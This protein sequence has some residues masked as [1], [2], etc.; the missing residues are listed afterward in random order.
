MKKFAVLLLLSMFLVASA[1]N[2][3]AEN[4]FSANIGLGWADEYEL[5]DGVDSV[6]LAFQQG[7]G[8]NLALGHSF[9]N[10]LRA[11]VELGYYNCDLDEATWAG[12]GSGH[13]RGDTTLLIAM[14]N[15]YYDFFPESGVSP[16]IGGGI[17]YADAE[18]S[19]SGASADDNVLVYQGI[20][21]LTFKVAEKGNVD[22]QYRYLVTD[23][24]ELEDGLSPEPFSTHN[25][26]VGFRINF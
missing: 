14:V 3:F 6:D 23:D 24:L 22:L 26:L 17:G 15:G 12:F 20:A 18:L 4:Y 5:S 21:G 7:W 16:F 10:P 13:L 11:E 19:I 2:V 8:A 1:S 25:V 9:N